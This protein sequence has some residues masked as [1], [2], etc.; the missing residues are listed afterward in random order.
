MATRDDYMK[1]AQQIA[2]HLD[3]YRLAFKT[4]NVSELD[5]MIAEVAGQGAR[6]TGGGGTTDQFKT[7]MLER[8]FVIHPE[9]GDAQDGYVRVIRSNSIVGNLLNAFKYVG[10]NGDEQLIRLL[11]Q[12]KRK[13]RPDDFTAEPIE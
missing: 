9:I 3:S 7:C 10:A 11:G 4:Y 2:Q 12:I 1:V 6:V 5:A 13:T 8:G